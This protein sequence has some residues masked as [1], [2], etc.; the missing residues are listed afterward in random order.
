MLDI[1]KIKM[2]FR[3]IFTP[4]TIMLVPHSK[5]EPFNVKVPF[6]GIFSALVLCCFGIA[7][8]F[9]IAVSAVEYY[10]MKNDLSYYS[11]QFNELNGTISS[12]KKAEGDFK[13][14]FSL[15][16]KEKVLEHADT[17][18]SGS[19]DME[20]LKKKIMQTKESVGEIKE[21]LHVHRDIYVS[22]PKGYPVH[23]NVSSPFGMREHP[24]T[25]RDDFHSGIDLSIPPGTPVRATADGIVT[26][27]G[28]HG[29]S[30]NLVSLE[31]GHGF[32]TFY[33]HNR[34]TV[35][36]VGQKVRRGDVLGYSGSTGNST[37]PHVHYEIWQDG[38]A[39]NPVGFQKGRA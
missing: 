20:D 2:L 10:K 8:L 25:G 11:R 21:Y 33:A 6:I 16:S 12:L 32:S 18:D 23:G 19:I 9:S 28:W 4:V 15:G 35:V 17:L 29:G 37:G 30:G 36:S 22:T 27:S 3:K 24:T 5:T 39:L 38:R 14:L 1:H 26:Y 7:Y 34:S 31:H 13:K